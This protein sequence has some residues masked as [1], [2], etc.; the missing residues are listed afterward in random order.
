MKTKTVFTDIF[1]LFFCSCILYMFNIRICPFY[2]FFKI[3]CPGC[4]LTRSI[5][6]L[7]KGNFVKSLEYNILGILVFLGCFIY[8]L[9]VIFKKVGVFDIFFKKHKII[10]I[11][12]SLILLVIVEIININ[13]MLLY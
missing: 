7:L 10:F 8:L 3:P 1:L 9:M 2:Y 4:G 11:I 6:E 13:N 5:I 12:L